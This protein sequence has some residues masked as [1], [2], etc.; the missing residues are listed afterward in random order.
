[1][2]T[3]RNTTAQTATATVTINAA[4]CAA[5]AACIRVGVA[6]TRREVY[7]PL[8]EIV[9]VFGGIP[10]SV[11]MQITATDDAI[12]LPTQAHAAMLARTADLKAA[13]DRAAALN[14][15][16]EV[17]AEY[18]LTPPARF[19]PK[20]TPAPV[21]APQT[22]TRPRSVPA[23]TQVAAPVEAPPATRSRRITAPPATPVQQVA[24]ETPPTV[25]PRVDAL[26][27]GMHTLTAQ[28]AALTAALTGQAT[29]EAPTKG[30]VRK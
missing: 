17:L 25:D 15:G 4:L 5:S 1:M 23:P 24:A 14:A 22:V 10:S 6:G 27:Q 7:L 8:E 26:E 16:Q 11:T 30:R 28:L 13:G 18:G 3:A 21:A 2:K 9:A 29:P 20:P 12:I 19:T